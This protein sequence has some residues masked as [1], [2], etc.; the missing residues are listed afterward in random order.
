M[1][2]TDAILV[3]DDEPSVADAIRLI[4]E[5]Q[6]HRV[7]VTASGVRGLSLARDGGVRLVITDL[8]LPDLSG[9]ELLRALRAERPRLPVVLITSYATPDLCEEARRAGA[10]AVLPKPFAPAALLDLLDGP[11]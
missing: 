1:E 7:L 5:D 2:Q 8:R 3:I 4:L 11:P 10:K 9:L 6:G